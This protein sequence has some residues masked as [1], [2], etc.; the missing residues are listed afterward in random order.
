MRC[1][2]VYA[3][4]TPRSSSSS[5]YLN[6]IYL[7]DQAQYPTKPEQR[8]PGRTVGPGAWRRVTPRRCF[9]IFV[10]RPCASGLQIFHLQKNGWALLQIIFAIRPGLLQTTDPKLKMRRW[11]IILTGDRKP[12]G[13][14]LATVPTPTISSSGHLGRASHPHLP[15]TALNWGTMTSR[16]EIRS[17]EETGL[18]SVIGMASPTSPTIV[19]P[20]ASVM[21]EATY[22]DAMMATKTVMDGAP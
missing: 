4:A 10:C 1:L 15:A 14:L 16:R 21:A 8:T 13:T 5:V 6:F 17:L 3:R 20:I 22:V 11:Q 9:C 18:I 7:A 19:H 12:T 2:V